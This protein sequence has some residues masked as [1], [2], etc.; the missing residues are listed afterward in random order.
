MRIIIA[1]SRDI[2]LTHKEVTDLLH[3]SGWQITE[4]IC[5]NCSGVDLSAATWAYMRG[6]PVE[7]HPANWKKH[8]K[9]AGPRRNKKMAKDADCLIA[10]WD[11][12]SRGTKNMIETMEKLNKPVFVK[13]YTHKK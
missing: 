3:Q 13:L 4:L 10:V 8:G 12:E 5:G 2:V 11:G 1:G 6:I 7:K 9:S